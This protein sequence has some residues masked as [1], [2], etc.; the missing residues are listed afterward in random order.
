MATPVAALV[1]RTPRQPHTQRATPGNV[2]VAFRP[3]RRAPW[4]EGFDTV[5]PTLSPYALA[6]SNGRY[7]DAENDFTNVLRYIQHSSCCHTIL[8]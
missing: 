2:R 1:V 7:I 4:A 6:L 8:Q 5:Q 3:P